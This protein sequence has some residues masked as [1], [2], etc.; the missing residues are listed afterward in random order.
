MIWLVK[1]I[2]PSHVESIFHRVRLHI[3]IIFALFFLPHH[4]ANPNFDVLQRYFC[5]LA[6]VFLLLFI[7]DECLMVH[8]VLSFSLLLADFIAKKLC[9][10]LDSLVKR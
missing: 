10:G 5:T 4:S 6:Q 1:T 9:L 7:S 3:S 8:Y 2:A